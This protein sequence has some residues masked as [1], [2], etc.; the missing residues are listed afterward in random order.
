[1]NMFKEA[2]VIEV[3]IELSK[4]KLESIANSIIGLQNMF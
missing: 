3:G 1:M 4:E 2:N